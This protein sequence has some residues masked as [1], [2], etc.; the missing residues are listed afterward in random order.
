MQRLKYLV[1]CDANINF[2]I[3]IG[4]GSLWKGRSWQTKAEPGTA[5]SSQVKPGTVLR[6]PIMCYIFEK[7]A[8]EDIKYDTERYV[9]GI[10]WGIIWGM[11]GVLS[12]ACLGHV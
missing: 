8:L 12:R 3:S 11:S 7:Q 6:R 2:I 5:G 4:S 10:N 1:R 9:W